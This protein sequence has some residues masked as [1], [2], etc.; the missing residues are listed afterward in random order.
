MPSNVSNQ[1]IV[2]TGALRGVELMSV[3]TAAEVNGKLVITSQVEETAKYAVRP[4]H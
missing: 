2:I 1:V 4:H 3:Q